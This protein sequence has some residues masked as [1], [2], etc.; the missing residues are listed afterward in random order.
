MKYNFDSQKGYFAPVCR[1]YYVALESVMANS[2]GNPGDD[3]ES[4]F[5]GDF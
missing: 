1:V 5:G 3:D 4:V 2:A